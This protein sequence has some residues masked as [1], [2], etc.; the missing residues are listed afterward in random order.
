[1]KIWYDACTGKHVRYG[2]MIARK[3]RKS[4]YQVIFTTRDH[5]DTVALANELGEKPLIVGKYDPKSLTT[6]LVESAKR[7][8]ELTRLLESDP[9]NLAISH[10]SVELCRVGFGL[11]TPIF[12]TAD[13]PH[14]TAV[15]KLTIPFSDALV[16]SEAIPTR[17]FR[18]HCAKRIIRFKGVD[19]ISW[20]KDLKPLNDFE[21]ARPLI[22]VR[23][24]ETKASYAERSD[25]QT[26][27][28]VEKLASMGNV[29]FLSRYTKRK[30]KRVRIIEGFIDSARLVAS[31]DLVVSAGGT[32]SREAALQG[33]P[34]IIVSEIGR[35][36]VNTYLAEKGFPL[37]FSGK[38]GVLALARKHLGK[39]YD[40]K[41]KM[42]QFQDPT[43]IIGNLVT[44]TGLARADE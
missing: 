9:P 15:N 41:Q 27:K 1:M 42:L 7:V 3:L 43:D 16:V 12:L 20:I 23:Q 4:G 10:Q 31:A 40:V 17:F 21:F 35:T 8:L 14:A 11:H 6:R 29:I 22:V 2:T 28:I 19:E 26:T 33:V 32:L 25:D 18:K 24:L 39:R 37:F 36:Y 38:S 34:S 44:E 30:M 13:T 5:P